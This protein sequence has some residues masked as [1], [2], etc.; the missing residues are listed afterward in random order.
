VS[1][2]DTNAP[3]NRPT[4]HQYELI[5]VAADESET[6]FLD[7]VV[8]EG[9][10]SQARV[11]IFVDSSGQR[12]RLVRRAGYAL[13]GLC[14]A[15][16]AML[17]LS[18]AGATS[19]APSTLLPVP[20]MP[21]QPLRTLAGG[22]SDA[23]DKDADDAKAKSEAPRAFRRSGGKGVVTAVEA[24]SSEVA[25]AGSAPAGGTSSPAGGGS[26]AAA[27]TPSP[28]RSSA[29]EAPAEPSKPKPPADTDPPAD[30][31]P[32]PPADPDPDPDPPADPD[33]DPDPPADPEPDPD[34][35]A[36]PDPDPDPPADP[37]P[38]G[39]PLDPVLD[40]VLEPV[41]DVLDVVGGIL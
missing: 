37:E 29:P 6:T 27:P 10:D 4:T 11:P 28:D 26:P 22:A 9:V 15:Y 39:G 40:P 12:A 32:D 21:T 16:T 23:A 2:T 1:N 35:P 34:P 20:G 24:P 19:I 13:T 31:D 41:E 5:D 3:E 7:R 8:R 30:P 14:A 36:D 38:T 18:L 25:V 33:P 17:G